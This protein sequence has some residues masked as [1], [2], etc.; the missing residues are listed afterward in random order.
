MWWSDFRSWV[1]GFHRESLSQRVYLNWCNRKKPQQKCERKAFWEEKRLC[2]GIKVDGLGM[3]FRGL[4]I[5]KSRR[6]AS[7]GTMCLS[8]RRVILAK[9]CKGPR[10]IKSWS[11]LEVLR[12]R[13]SDFQRQE[14]I[15]P[16]QARDPIFPS[17]ASLFNLGP[18]KIGWCPFALLRVK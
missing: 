18:Q 12:T 14:I 6:K 9:G 3:G 13:S 17:F 4:G 1:R 5:F 15:V 2:K 8:L 11:S 10:M 7:M 16:T